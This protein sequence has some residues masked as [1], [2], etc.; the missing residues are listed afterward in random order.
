M[1][2]RLNDRMND[3]GTWARGR[4]RGCRRTRETRA[5]ARASTRGNVER[6]SGTTCV[7]ESSIER[8]EA[9]RRVVANEEDRSIDRP[10]D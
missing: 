2:D 10:T 3:R 4:A 6:R 9:R 5:R 7:V 1:N 8:L